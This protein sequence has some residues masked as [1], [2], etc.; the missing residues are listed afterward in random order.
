[1]GIFSHDQIYSRKFINAEIMDSSQ[2]I[3]VVHIKYP[4]GEYFLAEIDGKIY[5]F[6]MKGKL[7]SYHHRAMFTTR[8]MYFTTAHYRPIDFENNKDLEIF[9][10]TNQLPNVDRTLLSTLK[11]LGKREKSKMVK[12]KPKRGVEVTEEEFQPHDLK[13]LA[14]VIQ[15]KEDVYSAQVKNLLTYLES[16]NVDQIVTPCKN[17][18]EFLEDNLI[19][20]DP[21][22]LG[23][24]LLTADETD[25]EHK[26]V[27]NVPVKGRGPML[28]IIAIAAIISMVGLTG[29]IAYDQGWF[30]GL[31]G[32][33]PGFTPKKETP[34]ECS[35]PEA[36]KMA[37]DAGKVK[38]S[39][40]PPDLQKLIDSVKLPTVQP[41]DHAVNLAQ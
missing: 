24:T 18:T 19:A 22:F 28:K 9:L 6:R 23:D 15:G 27:T 12:R 17:I 37:V 1:M 26:I 5:A 20:T 31:G 33:I 7:Y 29:W 36:C 21:K 4:I 3:Y 41:T 2:R 30:N 34:P 8:K 13:E 16:L 32:G 25:K 11:Y 38:K 14:K 39:D 10:R 35:S 40:L